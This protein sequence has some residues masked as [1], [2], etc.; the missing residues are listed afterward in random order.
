M[1]NVAE[2]RQIAQVIL[3]ADMVECFGIIEEQ[4]V[5]IKY[6]L[7][8]LLFC[9]LFFSSNTASYAAKELPLLLDPCNL[10]NNMDEPERITREII[11]DAIMSA[12][13]AEMNSLIDGDGHWYCRFMLGISLALEEYY[14]RELTYPSSIDK[15][16]ESGYLMQGWRDMGYEICDFD[17]ID[18][19]RAKCV[20]YIPQPLGDAEIIGVPGMT[21]C[22][23]MFS[24]QAYSIMIPEQ[25]RYLWMA[26]LERPIPDG[27]KSFAEIGSL[28]E[29]FHVNKKEPR[30]TACSCA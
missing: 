29:M 12:Q 9:Y 20:V 1:A 24:I 16:Y 15:L 10:S 6:T 22:H 27:V 28:V 23:T 7:S 14:V 18:Y 26:V 21:A 13:W 5:F 11:A 25:H 2:A 4:K 30:R 19:S 17:A 8:A 3:I